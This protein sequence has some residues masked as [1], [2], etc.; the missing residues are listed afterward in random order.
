MSSPTSRPDPVRLS[1]A[2]QAALSRIAGHERRRD[3][4]FADALARGDRRSRRGLGV[5]VTML[6]VLVALAFVVTALAVSGPWLVAIVA[7]G[8]LVVVP[9][10]LVVWAMR[11]GTVD[12]DARG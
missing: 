11:Q 6:V 5:G 12:P 8:V 4:R 10:G 7:V 9:S 2:E 3:P 1:T